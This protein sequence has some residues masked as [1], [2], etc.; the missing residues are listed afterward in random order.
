MLAKEHR[1]R[2]QPSA[3]YSSDTCYPWTAQLLMAYQY[4]LIAREETEELQCLSV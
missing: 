1:V 2:E 4:Q 3:I